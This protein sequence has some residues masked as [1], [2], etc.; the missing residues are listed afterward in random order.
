M[1]KTTLL[2]RQPSNPNLLVQHSARMM[3]RRA[4]DVEFFVQDVVIPTLSIEA[5]DFNTPNDRVPWPGDRL[6]RG[7]L[8][9]AFKVDEDLKN[10]EEI[11]S[12]MVGLV[13]PDSDSE[14]AKLKGA[15]TRGE[16]IFSDL[17]VFIYDSARRPKF[18]FTFVDAFPVSLSGLRFTTREDTVEPLDA[19]VAFRYRHFYVKKSGDSGEL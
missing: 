9:I 10:Y 8:E 18:E 13:A 2:S 16:G 15:A 1:T 7:D 5:A 3:L 4:P 6:Y 14:Y 17:T 11:R 12:W 19:D